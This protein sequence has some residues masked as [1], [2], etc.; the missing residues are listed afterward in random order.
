MVLKV[1]AIVFGA[2]LLVFGLVGYN[3]YWLA[4]RMAESNGSGW[5]SGLGLALLMRCGR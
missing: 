5:L 2:L 1:L 3:V 4:T